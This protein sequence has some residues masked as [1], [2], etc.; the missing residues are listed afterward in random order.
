MKTRKNVDFYLEMRK[1]YNYNIML[2]LI[3]TSE[4]KDVPYAE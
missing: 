4:R 3:L 1:K 2:C